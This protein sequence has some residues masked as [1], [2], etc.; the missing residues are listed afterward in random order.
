MGGALG[1]AITKFT[2]NV[3]DAYADA[4]SIVEQAVSGLR[5]VYAFTLQERFAQLYE[6]A[7]VKA[8]IAG[9]RRGV[10]LGGKQS[11]HFIVMYFMLTTSIQWALA[12]SC[13]CCLPPMDCPFGMVASS[14]L[15]ER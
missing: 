2:L 12:C 9:I 13:L 4:G 15:K 11:T 8:R 1:W 14:S 3:Q 10:F 6:K 7:L 5:T